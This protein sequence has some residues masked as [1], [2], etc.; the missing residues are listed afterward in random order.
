MTLKDPMGLI[1]G[2]TGSIRLPD[3]TVPVGFGSKL[4]GIKRSGMP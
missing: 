2:P 3:E 1:C 4:A